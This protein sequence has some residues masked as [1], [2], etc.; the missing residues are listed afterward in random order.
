M[1]AKSY[2]QQVDHVR[3]MLTTIAILELG[4]PPPPLL[5][6]YGPYEKKSLKAANSYLQGGNMQSTS[7]TRQYPSLDPTADSIRELC[8]PKDRLSP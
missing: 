2:V 6:I 7:Y 1:Y 5:C 3:D 4:S 8:M